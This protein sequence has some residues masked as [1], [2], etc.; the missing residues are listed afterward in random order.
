MIAL[1]LSEDLLFS[2]T[3]QLRVTTSLILI[4]FLGTHGGFCGAVQIRVLFILE[5]GIAVRSDVSYRISDY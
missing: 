4:G 5:L 3:S 2:I 1:Q